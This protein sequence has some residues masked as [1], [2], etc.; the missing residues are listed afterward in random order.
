MEK[1]Y[2]TIEGSKTDKELPQEGVTKEII[3]PTN[4]E[5]NPNLQSKVRRF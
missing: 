3:A 2:P 5:T 4:K 1:R